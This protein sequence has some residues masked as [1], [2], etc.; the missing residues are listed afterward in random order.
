MKTEPGEYAYENLEQDGW[1]PWDGVRNYQAQNN[2]RAMKKGDEVLIYH[3]V[4]PKTVVGIAKVKKEE[5]PDPTNDPKNPKDKWILVDV[6]PFKR[7]KSPVSLAQIKAE[8]SLADI[9]LIKQSRLSVMPLAKDAFDTIV[10]MS[11]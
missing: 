7:L 4:G 10:K 6:E 9:G 11:K 2:M 5:Y 1:T 8:P 3:S